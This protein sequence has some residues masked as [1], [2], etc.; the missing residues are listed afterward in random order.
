MHLPKLAPRHA[1]DRS[2]AP[3]DGPA[4]APASGARSR[5]STAATAPAPGPR[6][7]RRT[8]R[9][10]A[11]R[12]V[13]A[14]GTVLPRPPAPTPA[15]VGFTT[16]VVAALT[17]AVAVMAPAPAA[18]RARDAAAA[19][20]PVPSPATPAGLPAGIESLASYVGQTSC[21]PVAKPGVLRLSALLT[22]T[23]P[24]TSAW[25]PRPC[26]LD[27]PGMQ[28]EHYEGRALDWSVSVRNPLAARRAAAVIA[29]L[30]APDSAGRP[31]AMARRLGIMYIIWN[32]QMWRAYQPSWGWKPYRDCAAH[33]EPGSDTGCHRDHIHFSLSWAGAAG[34]TSFWTGS[35][36]ANDYGPCRPADLNWAPPYGGLNP[37]P[38]RSFP[39]VRAAAGVSTL[40]TTLVVY[41]GATIGPGSTGPVVT[42]V[43]KAL[44][45]P[46]TA[47]YGPATSAAVS[48]FRTS[49]KLRAGTTVDAATWRALLAAFAVPSAAPPGTKPVPPA[50]PPGTKPAPVAPADPLAR[51]AGTVLRYGARGDAVVAVQRALRV[52]PVSGW[53][54]PATRSAVVA[55]QKA[56]GIPTTG[57]V[58][59]LT[60]HALGG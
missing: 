28:S 25:S 15:L 26:G 50:S 51:Y 8:G 33:P 47:T 24:G 11:T 57:N 20:P 19:L 17:V 40:G 9:R 49:H 18:V 23:Y 31:A 4:A 30:L 38:C 41:S 14:T 1:T 60:W 12:S 53:F 42:A 34:R 3:G 45:V 55:Y 52:S 56:H 16:T 7:A 48:A 44:V 6:R 37:V 22:R 2:A 35:V 58:G 13:T 5:T 59:P 10:P 54:G 32:N 39:Q 43:Q 29:W 21:D 36:A 27:G 46:A